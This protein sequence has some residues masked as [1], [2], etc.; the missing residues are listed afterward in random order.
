MA[1]STSRSRFPEQLA[2]DDLREA[3]R[4][5]WWAKRLE[6]R[7]GAGFP[8]LT[9]TGKKK[10]FRWMELKVLPDLPQENR[11]FDIRHFTSEQRA[12]GLEAL[13]H[14]GASS[15][16]LMTRLGGVDHLHKATIIDD[17]G[18]IKYSVFRNRAA[19]IG[20]IDAESAPLLAQLLLG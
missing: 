15:W 12:F 6:D 8:D 19:W 14:G 13:R 3:L 10:G 4:P 1:A 5:Y 9:F 7:L 17:L 20:H 16:W 18:E 2:W 11:K